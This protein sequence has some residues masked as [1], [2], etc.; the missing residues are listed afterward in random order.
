MML[1]FLP[2]ATIGSYAW[3]SAPAAKKPADMARSMSFSVVNVSSRSFVAS[4]EVAVA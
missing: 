1:A 4:R 2:E 3:P